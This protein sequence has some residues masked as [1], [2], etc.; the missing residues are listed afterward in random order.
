M[1][2]VAINH[3]VYFNA[4]KCGLIVAEMYIVIGYI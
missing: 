3:F 1:N 2:L 4:Y